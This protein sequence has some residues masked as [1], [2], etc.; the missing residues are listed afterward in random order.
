MLAVTTDQRRRNQAE[1]DRRAG[2]SEVLEFKGLECRHELGQNSLECIQGCRQ[3]SFCL[4]FIACRGALRAAVSFAVANGLSRAK[5][6]GDGV[7]WGLIS[8]QVPLTW[9]NA[10]ERPR[11]H[12]G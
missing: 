2:S 3:R 10:T 12:S 5:G 1:G 4:L 9:L 8:T 7:P 11:K 6:G